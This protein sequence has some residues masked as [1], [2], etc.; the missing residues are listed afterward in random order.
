MVCYLVQYCVNAIIVLY[1]F[2]NSIGAVE[3]MRSIFTSYAP[4]DA[5]QTE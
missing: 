1:L 5:N 4:N 2:F 3:L